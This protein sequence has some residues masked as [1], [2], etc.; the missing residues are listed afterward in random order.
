MLPQLL[1]TFEAVQA[2]P[3]SKMDQNQV[4]SVLVRLSSQT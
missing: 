1:P 2:D 4:F 3:N